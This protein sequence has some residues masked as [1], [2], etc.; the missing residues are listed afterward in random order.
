MKASWILH[1]VLASTLANAGTI[2]I[3]LS[4]P[5]SSPASGLSPL[6]EIIPPNSGGS[7][8]TIDNGISLDTTSLTLSLAIGY[9]SAE[10]FAD[11]TGPAFAWFLHGP[12]TVFE[13]AP[14]LFDLSPLHSFAADP[15]HGGTIVGSIILDHQEENDLLAGLDYVNIYT[16]LNPG[17]EIRAQ[18]VPVINRGGVADSVSTIALLG[19]VS[20][21]V[22]SLHRRFIKTSLP[23]P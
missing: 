15:A 2:E 12:A 20:I 14:V 11:L 10:G 16:G 19:F 13:T 17:G 23:P 6:N 9:G 21:G 5:G 3:H 18:L 1:V 22:V 4:P 7:G 8:G